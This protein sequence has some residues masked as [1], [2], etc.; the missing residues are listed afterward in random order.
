MEQSRH[1]NASEAD[2]NLQFR[3]GIL[4]IMAFFCGRDVGC[5]KRYIYGLYRSILHARSIEACHF[6]T[7]IAIT[8]PALDE[9]SL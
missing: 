9:S 7:L 2:P 6:S 1:A 4:A 5:I 3:N 8:V